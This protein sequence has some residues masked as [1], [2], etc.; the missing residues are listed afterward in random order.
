MKMFILALAVMASS[1]LTGCGY[2]REYSFR[3]SGPGPFSGKKFTWFNP[4]AARWDPLD[5]FPASQLPADPVR[6]SETIFSDLDGL[7]TGGVSVHYHHRQGTDNDAHQS[8]GRHGFDKR[9]NQRTYNETDLDIEPNRDQWMWT[10]PPIDS[11]GDLVVPHEPAAPQA[12]PQPQ[13]Q[14]KPPPPE[15]KKL[16]KKP[17]TTGVLQPRKCEE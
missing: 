5:A 15:P 11:N 16:I 13:A 9:V 4:E 17:C 8:W 14:P 1:L 12:Q 3:E 10:R 6:R 2:S 7:L